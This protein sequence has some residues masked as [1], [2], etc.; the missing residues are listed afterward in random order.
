[1][2]YGEDVRAKIF[3]PA[4]ASAHF[5]KLGCLQGKGGGSNSKS[6]KRLVCAVIWGT[7]SGRS[8]QVESSL[9]WKYA[10]ALGSKAKVQ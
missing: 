1:M 3:V 5:A 6:G 10:K 2:G 7:P 8:S 9:P 4:K